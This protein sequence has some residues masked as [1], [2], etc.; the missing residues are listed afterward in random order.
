MLK[1][2]YIYLLVMCII[3]CMWCVGACVVHVHVYDV[4]FGYV[5]NSVHAYVYV[6]EHVHVWMCM[7]MCSVCVRV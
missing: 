7:C 6:N 5:Y 4:V 2:I 1:R 3:V